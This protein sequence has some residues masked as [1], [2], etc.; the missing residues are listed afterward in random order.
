MINLIM[1]IYLINNAT[2][3]PFDVG[4]MIRNV[5]NYD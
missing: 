2:V 5:F 3:M 1:M 4:K